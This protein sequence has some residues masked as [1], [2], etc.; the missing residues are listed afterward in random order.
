MKRGG[1]GRRNAQLL[2]LVMTGRRRQAQMMMGRRR[3]AQMMMGRRRQAQMMMMMAR[4]R[5]T[6]RAG[7]RGG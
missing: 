7:A 1:G 6:S 4:R 5:S 3:Q 2:P